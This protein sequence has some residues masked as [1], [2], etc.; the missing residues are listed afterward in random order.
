DGPVV[1]GRRRGLPQP[2][3]L[4]HRGRPGPAAR[5]GRLPPADDGP[6]LPGRGVRPARVRAR[7]G[8]PAGTTRLVPGAKPPCPQ[9]P[10]SLPVVPAGQR[11]GPIVG[12]AFEV[13]TILDRPDLPAEALDVDRQP[14]PPLRPHRRPPPSGPRLGPARHGH[15]P[16]IPTASRPG[17]R[18][19]R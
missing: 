8:P 14:S 1:Q 10:P 19:V 4:P 11:R 18:P 9:P 7:P 6:G 3:R 17:P 13:A 15:G 5:P 2:R 16:H 12:P